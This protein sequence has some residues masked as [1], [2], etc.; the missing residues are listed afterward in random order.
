MVPSKLGRLLAWE[1]DAEAEAAFAV[2]IGYERTSSLQYTQTERK[3]AA[4]LASLIAVV[5]VMYM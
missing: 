3:P 5:G 4:E 2:V 1:V